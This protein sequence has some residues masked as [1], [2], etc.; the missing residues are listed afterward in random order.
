MEI[1]MATSN[2]LTTQ[3]V[4]GVLGVVFGLLFTLDNLEV[5]DISE[6]LM[7]WPVLLVLLGAVKL[8]QPET[9]GKVWGGVFV[10]LGGVLLFRSL[11]LY[12]IRFRDFWP[13]LLVLVG[14]ALLWGSFARRKQGSEGATS[15]SVLNGIA[16]LGG[17]KRTI[18]SQDFQGGELTAVLGGCEIDLRH[19]VI[20]GD[21]AVISIFAFWGGVELRVPENWTVVLQG[22]PILGGFSDVTRGTAGPGAKRLVI[23]GTAIMGGAEVKN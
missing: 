12:Y 1:S 14:G 3:L 23:T 4:A 2:R 5:I 18:A 15:D 7:Y 20:R 9:A 19:A 11:D 13:L 8:L 6:Y 16:I 22:L 21:E 17:F 10:I